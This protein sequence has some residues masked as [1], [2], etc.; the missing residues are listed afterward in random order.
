[1]AP[2][3]SNHQ[4]HYHYKKI[5]ESILLKSTRSPQPCVAFV[6]PPC[7]IPQDPPPLPVT[8]ETV[9]PPQPTPSRSLS[10]P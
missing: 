1:M 6:A 4:G 9:T 3:W 2:P 5:H 7:S 10:L 8:V